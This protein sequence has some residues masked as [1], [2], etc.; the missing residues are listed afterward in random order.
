[1][2]VLATLALVMF[3]QKEQTN[4]RD[5]FTRSESM[6]LGATDSGD[7]TQPSATYGSWKQ[8][9]RS[10]G[11]NKWT[12]KPLHVIDGFD[13]LSEAEYNDVIFGALRLLDVDYLL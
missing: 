11:S 6:P 9:W 12:E 13:D 10:K 4:R 5:M 3:S 7:S 8:L 2:A 1:M